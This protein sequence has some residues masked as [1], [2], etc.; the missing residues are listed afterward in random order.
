MMG[1]VTSC[2]ENAISDVWYRFEYTGG[3]LTLIL[4][5]GLT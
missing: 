1:P 2:G 4:G 3:G 5:E